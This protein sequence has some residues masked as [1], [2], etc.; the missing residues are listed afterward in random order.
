V[1]RRMDARSRSAPR[2]AEKDPSGL[3]TAIGPG[4]RTPSRAGSRNGASDWAK[5]IPRIQTCCVR[6]RERTLRPTSALPHVWKPAWRRG[7]CRPPRIWDARLGR[8]LCSSICR[9][10]QSYK[11]QAFACPVPAERS[12][13]S[14]GKMDVFYSNRRRNDG[15]RSLGSHWKRSKWMRKDGSLVS[16]STQLPEQAKAG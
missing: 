10:I 3:P 7:V 16:A 5:A 15:P 12:G 4:H 9:A 11:P 2:S 1:A 14:C 8:G 13:S 6:A